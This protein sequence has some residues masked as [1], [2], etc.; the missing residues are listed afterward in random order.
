MQDPCPCAH[1]MMGTCN[2]LGTRIPPAQLTAACSSLLGKGSLALAPGQRCRAVAG[3]GSPGSATLPWHSTGAGW[4][5]PGSAKCPG[6]SQRS[7]GTKGAVAADTVQAVGR[8]GRSRQGGARQRMGGMSH[9]FP[10]TSAQVLSQELHFPALPRSACL[11]TGLPRAGVAC[12]SASP[13][14]SGTSSCWWQSL[15][16]CLLW[17]GMAAGG[18]DLTSWEVFSRTALPTACPTRKAWCSF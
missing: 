1:G 3:M 5:S 13:C 15:C 10:H 2:M 11:C 16:L 14:G 4:S 17:K 6:R 12:C 18:G 8:E 7:A 9:P